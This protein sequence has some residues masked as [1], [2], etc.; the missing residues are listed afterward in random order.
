MASSLFG[1]FN[2]MRAYVSNNGLHA[3]EA[4]LLLWNGDVYGAAE[5]YF[6]HST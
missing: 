3:I 2:Q 5:V 4:D 6:E 1:D